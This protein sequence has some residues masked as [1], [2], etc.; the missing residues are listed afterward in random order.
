MKIIS[1]R[2]PVAVVLADG[3]VFEF[4]DGHLYIWESEEDI[5]T[6]KDCLNEY[7]LEPMYRIDEE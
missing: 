2:T 3:T 5:A 4:R 6:D 1:G 7:E